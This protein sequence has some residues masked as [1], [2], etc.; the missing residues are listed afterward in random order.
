MDKKGFTLVELLATIAILVLMSVIIGVNITSILR[1]T[2]KQND[3]FDKKQIEKAACVYVDSTLNT[4]NKCGT[5][6]GTCTSVTV[7][8]LIESGLLDDSY[9]S[10]KS[11][12][13]TINWTDGLKKCT[14]N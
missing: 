7:N 10:V 14:Y 4:Y 8:D 9:E 6:S 13:V 12:P 2:E 1:S 3:D 5:K 11:K